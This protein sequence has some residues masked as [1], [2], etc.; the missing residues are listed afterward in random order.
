MQA[1]EKVDPD[2][3]MGGIT[4]VFLLDTFHIYAER[5]WMLY[6]D[7]CKESI[8][9]TIAMLRACQMG[10]VHPDELNKW[11]DDGLNHQ[12]DADKAIEKMQKEL[13]SFILN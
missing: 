7:L 10:I 8:P 3:L 12:D 5:I 11:V 4:H 1:A 9:K 6:K 13:P 2:A